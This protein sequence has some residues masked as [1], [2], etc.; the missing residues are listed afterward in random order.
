MDIQNKKKLF[1]FI[2]ILPFSENRALI[3]TT[4]FSKELISQ[5]KYKEDLKRYIKKKFNGS[6]YK[7]KSSEF[8]IIPMFKYKTNN[9]LNHIKIGLAGNWVKQSTG[10]SLQNSFLYSRQIVD[11]ILKGK[12][13]K[14]KEKKI[15][16]FLDKTFCVFIS[17]N[18]D[19]A[20]LF[21]EN[22]FKNNNL[23]ILVKFMTNTANFFE[24]FKIVFSLPKLQIIKSI[25]KDK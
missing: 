13:P 8:G 25:V 14:I 7:I 19:K 5:N 1:N 9:S 10:Y 22:F 3:E 2:Y 4:Y 11:C 20:K 17:N 24:I 18:P 16:Y 6:N 23:R 12:T 21:F 15:Y